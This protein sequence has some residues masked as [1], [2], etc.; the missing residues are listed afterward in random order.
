M[1]MPA[2]GPGDSQA[3]S[4][5]YQCRSTEVISQDCSRRA[6]GPAVGAMEEAQ[7]LVWPNPHVYVPT[8]PIAAKA[9]P[10]TL[11]VYLDVSQV[12]NLRSRQRRC[13]S[14]VHTAVRRHFSSSSLVTRPLGRSCGFSPTSVCGL[15][16]GICSRGCKSTEV[17]PGGR[18][19]KR[20]QGTSACAGRR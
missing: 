9:R 14:M 16:T 10:V 8:K 2:I 6:P 7:S 15:P 20:D 18:D 1:S 13:K 11:V 12:L 17:H 19:L 4:L 5:G 3:F